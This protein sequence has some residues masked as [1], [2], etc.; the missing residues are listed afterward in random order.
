VEQVLARQVDPVAPLTTMERVALA[1]EERRRWLALLTDL[2][3]AQWGALSGCEG[4]TVKDLAAHLAGQGEQLASPVAA[5]KQGRAGKRLARGR[6][7]VDGITE[8]QV[9]VRAGKRPHEVVAELERVLPAAER[10]RR[11]FPW[12]STRLA[13]RVE[14]LQ[15][16]GSITKERWPLAYMAQVLTR[17]LWMHRV[18]VTQALGRRMELTA[19][20]DRRLLE[21]VVVDWARRHGQPFDLRL[22]GPAGGHWIRGD[23]GTYLERDA[24]DFARGLF[25]RG[26]PPPSPLVAVVPF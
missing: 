12:T 26:A 19:A 7:L 16:D 17:D 8:H 14:V 23:G 21:D 3:E 10:S 22:T 6:A 18:D 2:D 11:R 20:H 1:A 5:A 24:V 9:G 25:G 4:W 15:P 13:V